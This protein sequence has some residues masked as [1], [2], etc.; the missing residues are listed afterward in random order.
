MG[1]ATANPVTLP[2]LYEYRDNAKPADDAGCERSMVVDGSV[3][4]DSA[5]GDACA[6]LYK[7]VRGGGGHGGGGRGAPVCVANRDT[8]EPTRTITSWSGEEGGSGGGGR[9]A[10]RR[11]AMS[12]LAR[13]SS[14]ME[15]G[16]TP[17]ERPD[18]SRSMEH[19]EHGAAE[20]GNV[21]L[22]LVF[23]VFDRKNS[24]N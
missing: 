9:G 17:P 10:P 13:S 21:S 4:N 23:S 6:A 19:L 1:E 2:P 7:T 12:L 18:D 8:S 22:W 24:R 15:H 11:W 20:K 3:L 14:T 5:V 16:I